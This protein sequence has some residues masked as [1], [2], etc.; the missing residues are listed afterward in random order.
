MVPSSSMSIA[1]ILSVLL[2]Y[3]QQ[4][5]EAQGVVIFDNCFRCICEAASGC[6]LT[7]GCDGPVCGPYRITWSYWA[8]GGKLKL[9]GSPDSEAYPQCVNNPHCAVRTVQGYMDKFAQD[10]NGDGVINCDDYL[11]IHRL[12][13]YGCTGPLDAKYEDTFK[14]CKETL[15]NLDS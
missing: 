15:R 14:R 6:N 10:C 1:T 8:D 7:S 4:V 11:R 12:G 9:D 13:G 5:S 3:G 2:I